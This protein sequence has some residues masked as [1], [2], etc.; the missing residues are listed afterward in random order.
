MNFKEQNPLMQQLVREHAVL[1]SMNLAIKPGASQQRLFLYAEAM[2][3]IVVLEHLL[4]CLPDVKASAKLTLGPLLDCAM[5]AEVIALPEGITKKQIIDFRNA[6][7]HGNLQ[8]IADAWAMSVAEY[9]GT[10]FA[11]DLELLSR[12]VD[13]LVGQVDVD[14]GRRKSNLS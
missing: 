2:L 4:R 5:G 11:I 10:R 6:V 1:R 12:V 8:Q 9:C 7:L 14:T 3:V 13:D